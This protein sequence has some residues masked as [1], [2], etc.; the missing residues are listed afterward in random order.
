MKNRALGLG[1]I[2]N[3]YTDIHTEFVSA[4]EVIRNARMETKTAYYQHFKK[5]CLDHG[6]GEEEYDRFMS[7]EILTDYLLTNTDRHMNNIGIL[8]DPDTLEWKGFAP[9]YDTGN[10]MFFRE[11]DLRYV[12]LD[13][14]KTASLL[15][16]ERKLL[17]FVKYPRIVDLKA[18]PG[19]DEFFALYEQDVPERHSRIE[20]MWNLFYAKVRRVRTM[21]GCEA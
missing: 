4:W 15:D 8:R 19:R 7:Y 21:Q 17:R 10:A 11:P 5:Q 2:C 16:R 14:V 18:L 12:D 20:P 13:D 9:I 3:C 1:C 6:I